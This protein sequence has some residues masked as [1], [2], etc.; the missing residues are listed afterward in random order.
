MLHDTNVRR[1]LARERVDELARDFRRAQRAATHER[2][3]AQHTVLV[4]L[5]QRLRKRKPEVAA[6]R[7]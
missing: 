7:P 4:A 6:Q 2:P 1:Q 3:E 5:L